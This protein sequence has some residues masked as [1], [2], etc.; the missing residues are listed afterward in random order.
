MR[1]GFGSLIVFPAAIGTLA[2]QASTLVVQHART[3]PVQD[4]KDFPLFA[5]LRALKHPSSTLFRSL[6]LL[7]PR[8]PPKN[9]LAEQ[10]DGGK[11][12]FLETLLTAFNSDSTSS[13]R[14]GDVQAYYSSS[15]VP[16][17]SVSSASPDAGGGACDCCGAT[18]K[19][20][21][22]DPPGRA[23]VRSA[24]MRLGAETG[25]RMPPLPPP[26]P[27]TRQSSRLDS[28]FAAG[29]EH[30]RKKQGREGGAMGGLEQFAAWLEERRR[31]VSLHEWV[32]SERAVVCRLCDVFFFFFPGDAA[33]VVCS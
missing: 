30:T 19:V 25:N 14:N 17:A 9:H 23:R 8:P 1:P 31:E 5:F 6:L 13:S 32:R 28:A 21:G 18:L 33:V 22:L 4:C 15:A 29:E 2:S 11:A 12:G 3:G 7:L 20:M 16:V 24:L 27:R 10:A 26:Q